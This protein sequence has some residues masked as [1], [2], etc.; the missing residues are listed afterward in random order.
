MKTVFIAGAMGS[1]KTTLGKALSA[2]FG[3]SKTSFGAILRAWAIKNDLPT[4]RGL[5]QTVG[6]SIYQSRSVE[7]YIDWFVKRIDVDVDSPFILDGVRHVDAYLV[8]KSRFPDSVLIFCEE[9][10]EK[11][12]AR[13][14]RRDEI[15]TLSALGQVMHPLEQDVQNLKSRADY[16]FVTND[17]HL[18]FGGLL[19]V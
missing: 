18:S 2:E 12:V 5:L 10:K 19:G 13:I 3:Y 17:S 16:I 7:D 15:S 14:V 6:Y 8:L 4:D 1:G 9:D 11:R